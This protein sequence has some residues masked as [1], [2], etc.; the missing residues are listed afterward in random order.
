[1]SID[2][3]VQHCEVMDSGMLGKRGR[4]DIKI[5][6]PACCCM[7]GRWR[8]HKRGRNAIRIHPWLAVACEGGGG[9]TWFEGGGDVACLWEK[10]SWFVNAEMLCLHLILSY[11]YKSFRFTHPIHLVLSPRKTEY[12]QGTLTTENSKWLYSRTSLER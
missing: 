10:Q 9:G 3:A 7:R 1:V 12:M 6:S 11:S 8:T 2:T 4:N 5:I